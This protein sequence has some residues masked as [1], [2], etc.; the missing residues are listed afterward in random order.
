MGVAEEITRMRAR[1][2]LD[3]GYVKLQKNHKIEKKTH[4]PRKAPMGFLGGREPV[5]RRRG[6]VLKVRAESMVAVRLPESSTLEAPNIL[7]VERWGTG[8]PVGST[9]G[10]KMGRG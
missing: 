9:A 8:F 1:A 2:L 10:T 6:V 5:A 7:S 3:G 4:P